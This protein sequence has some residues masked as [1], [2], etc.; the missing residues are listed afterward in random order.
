MSR[1]RGFHVV[2]ALIAVLIC[3]VVLGACGGGGSSSGGSTAE[4]GSSSEEGNSTTASSQSEGGQIDAGKPPVRIPVISIKIPGLDLLTPQAA[5]A[6]AAADK[7][8]AEG[9]FGGREVVVEECATQLTPATATVCANQTL[10]KG[11]V[12]AEVGCEVTW[13][14]SG[15]KIYEKA[16]VPSMNCVNGTSDPG[17]FSGHPGAF[18]LQAGEAAWLC[19]RPE[20][21]N[22]VLLGQDLATQKTEEEVSTEPIIKGCGKEIHYVFAPIE[23]TDF[24]PFVNKVLEYEPDF[25]IS[26][27]SPAPTAQMFKTFQQAGYPADQVSVVESSCALEETLEPAGSAMEGAYCADGFYPYTEESN[28]EVAAY[29]EAMQE[30]DVGYSY[31]S[32]SPPYGYSSVMWIY[33]GAKEIGF[34]K[35]T[36]EKLGEWMGSVKGKTYPLSNEWVNPGPTISSSVHQPSTL[37]TQWKGGTFSVVEEGT[38]EGWIDGFQALEEAEK[39]GA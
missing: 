23:T 32:P 10:A 18:G 16:G 7:I 5:G 37:I 25:V 11:N 15:L 30:N 38:E 1:T 33:Q 3:A 29:V 13:S 2:V 8:N 35:V 9:G 34:D 21:K 24:T 27:Q 28:P 14:S 22:I 4:G 12:M 17:N 19:E 39:G 36:P 6:K 20:I 26:Q 31:K